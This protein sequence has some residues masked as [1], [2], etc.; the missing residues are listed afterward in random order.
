MS[1]NI[2]QGDDNIEDDL[3]IDKMIDDQI[4]EV[5]SRTAETG[6]TNHQQTAKTE[7]ESTDKSEDGAESPTSK[8]SQEES[9]ESAP[10]EVIDFKNP[11]KGRN[12]SDTAYE[13]RVE[14]SHLVHMRK[15]AKN[16]D[17]R[18]Q[19]QDDIYKA[20][21]DLRKINTEN[22]NRAEISNH[23]GTSP[24]GD[25]TQEDTQSMI[26][27]GIAVELNKIQSTQVV[28]D[29]IKSNKQLQDEDFREVFFDFID[30]D[31]NWQGKSPTQLKHILDLA[32][33]A[34]VRPEETFE[35]KVIKSSKVHEAVTAMQFP[36][37][38]IAVEGFSKE[39][40]SDISELEATGMSREKAIVLT[41]GEI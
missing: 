24:N 21:Q 2:Q 19:I 29:F 6:D 33:S 10:E 25:T 36:G 35:D 18:N 15:T 13:K 7:D 16:T 23:E 32:Y 17:E 27:R 38:S 31:F 40:E 5:K 9:E 1:E 26:Q 12:E 20:R 14:L 11:T 8:A 34:M 30:S 3:S 41:D 28:E 37:G 39:R 4:E 22:F